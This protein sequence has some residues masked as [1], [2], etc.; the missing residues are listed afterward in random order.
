MSPC[1]SMTATEPMR[2]RLMSS[3]FVLCKNEDEALYP[4]PHNIYSK[5]RPG[6]PTWHSNSTTLWPSRKSKLTTC[7]LSWRTDWTRQIIFHSIGAL[8]HEKL[9]EAQDEH[10]APSSTM[11]GFNIWMTIFAKAHNT[12][13][14]SDIFHCVNKSLS[15]RHVCN[16]WDT[17]T[18]LRCWVLFC[19][20][21]YV[22]PI[23]LIKEVINQSPTF[24][25]KPKAVVMCVVWLPGHQVKE[26][27]SRRH[28]KKLCRKAEWLHAGHADG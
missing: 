24:V 27:S 7:C 15:H 10:L 22:C 20:M 3:K 26:A 4:L 1:L 18:M 28:C 8:Q 14:F 11:P 2:P 19:I 23:L 13:C 12:F 6:V 16:V 21:L 25:W 5:D 17:W 9:L